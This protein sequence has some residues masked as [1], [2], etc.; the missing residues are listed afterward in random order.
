MKKQLLSFLIII[1]FHNIFFSETFIKE[2]N[3]SYQYEKEP[4][5]VLETEF[6]FD[7]SLLPLEYKKQVIVGDEKEDTFYSFFNKGDEFLINIT[8]KKSKRVYTVSSKDSKWEIKYFDEVIG[9][10]F[11]SDDGTSCFFIDAETGEKEKFSEIQNDK[12]IIYL[13]MPH[14]YTLKN[15]VFYEENSDPSRNVKIDYNF[16]KEEYNTYVSVE[17]LESKYHFSRNYYCISNLQIIILWIIT[18]MLQVTKSFK[19]V[20]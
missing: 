3:Y 19:P 17:G 1:I 20:I 9:Y 18:S 11:F 5:S 10:L 12:Y 6:I 14:T 8:E 4:V 13:N 16:K 2:K 7:N 15:N